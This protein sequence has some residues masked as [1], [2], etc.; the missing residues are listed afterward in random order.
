M[1]ILEN[2]SS[3]SRDDPRG[4]TT[5][6]HDEADNRFIAN[7]W[8]RLNCDA[9]SILHGPHAAAKRVSQFVCDTDCTC[10]SHINHGQDV[11]H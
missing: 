8:T 9:F 7:L 6:S 11:Q 1:K 3:W 5:D 10:Y 2:P 4:R